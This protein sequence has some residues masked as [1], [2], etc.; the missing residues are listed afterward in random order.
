MIYSLFHAYLCLSHS[1]KKYPYQQ[2]IKIIKLQYSFY[3][4]KKVE[5]DAFLNLNVFSVGHALKNVLVLFYIK[6]HCMLIQI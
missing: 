3:C 2:F 1:I 6:L 5:I 4:V